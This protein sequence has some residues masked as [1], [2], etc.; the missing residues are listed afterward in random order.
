MVGKGT[1]WTKEEKT[2]I[3]MGVLSNSSTIG[4][5]YQKY[6]VA[7]P[8]AYKKRGAFTAGTT[9]IE[10]GGSITKAPLSREINEVKGIIG[11]LMI[12]NE[13]LK[14]IQLTRRGGKQ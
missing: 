13:T 11:K 1:Y 10:Y 3:L 4:E 8:A 2:R 12:V 9:A 7:S 14:K 5:I 6:N